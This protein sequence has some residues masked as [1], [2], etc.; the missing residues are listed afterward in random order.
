MKT[1][2][3]LALA[4]LLLLSWLCFIG[5]NI[6]A[7]RDDHAQATLNQFVMTASG[8]RENILN[9]RLGL[10]R[11]YDP[12]DQKTILLHQLL[13]RLRDDGIPDSV[14]N[15]LAAVVN[16][17]DSLTERFK[18]DNALLQNSL[19]YFGLLSGQFGLGAHDQ[20]FNAVITALST[21]VLH[22]MLD[23]S[24]GSAQQVQD[25]LDHLANQPSSDS[26][27]LR[28]GLLTHGRTLRT[29]LPATDDVLRTLYD[30]PMSAREAAVRSAIIDHQQATQARADRY[31]LLL[32]SVSLLL[33]LLLVGLGMRLRHILL[34]LRRRAAFEH[35]IAG[36]SMTFVTA[37][38]T[39]VREVVEKALAVLA[40]GIGADRGYFISSVPQQ[41]FA[42]SRDGRAWLANRPSEA[43]IAVPEIT[44]H[45]DDILYFP[46]VKQMADGSER[47]ALEA[48]G[49]AGWLYISASSGDGME[50]VLGF[51]ALA[52]SMTWP[53]EDLGLIRMAADTIGNAVG[54][55]RLEMEQVR[56]EAS[57]QKAKRMETVGAL[58]SGVAHNFNN[59]IGSILGHTE[60]QEAEVVP[61]SRLARHVQ[62]V[63]QAAERAR[64]L[65]EQILHFGRQKGISEGR[66]Q[67]SSL[68]IETVTQLAV[69]LPHETRL[70]VGQVPDAAVVRG[71]PAQLQQIIVN[72][73]NNAS[74]AMG[75]SGVIDI[76]VDMLTVSQ[77]LPLSHGRV[78]PG[79]YVRVAVT[80]RGRGMRAAT[81]ERLFEPFFTTR[82]DG[83]GLGLATAFEIVTSYGGAFNVTSHPGVGSTFVVWLPRAEPTTPEPPMVGSSQARGG[84][85]TVLV[86]NED[87]SRL[88]RDEEIVAALGYEPIGYLR[89]GQAL[90]AF[91][92]APQRFDLVLIS[93]M[94]SVAE[95]LTFAG[96]FHVMSPRTPIL[97]SALTET[98][99][100]GALAKAGVSGV[101]KTPITSADLAAS[102][103]RWLSARP[104]A[105]PQLQPNG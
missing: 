47:D 32:Y 65:V 72:L 12:L 76:T 97:L 34:T 61:G 13:Q 87:A 57:L 41:L 90:A 63:R 43:P 83:N 55:V 7:P 68:L 38:D 10:L 81:L 30:L 1:I 82:P 51:E 22:L 69:A 77:P 79:A 54:R 96:K 29:L 14:V 17:Q 73:C 71:D 103:S 59:V 26:E 98:L 33:L 95:A 27:D 56:L 86:V 39:N 18:S 50:Y 66:V 48:G 25:G 94:A 60:M 5:T 37:R 102:I 15:P 67:M 104:A 70:V 35:A 36:I 23:P 100:A 85:E 42:W 16:R 28:N 62:G 9:A 21:S 58:T 2:A 31:R 45:A 84:G 74:Q 88:L 92:L 99:G 20:S 91:G 8:L 40:D 19:A 53:S 78:P 6:S 44:K 80:D 3:S 93:Y 101:V 89:P 49:L 64:D 4:A 11:N 46:S 105:T 24:A 52:K 75:G